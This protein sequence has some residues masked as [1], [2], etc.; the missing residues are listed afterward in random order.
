G[1]RVEAIVFAHRRVVDVDDLLEDEGHRE[2]EE[3]LLAGRLVGWKGELAV[4]VD[5]SGVAS[6]EGPEVDAVF[7][8]FVEE[9]VEVVAR[10]EEVTVI[11]H[12]RHTLHQ[13]LLAVDVEAVEVD[14]LPE[15]QDAA[16]SLGEAVP[17]GRA[18]QRDQLRARE[19]RGPIDLV[20]KDEPRVRI[21][22]R[23]TRRRAQ[24]GNR[25]SEPRHQ[26]FSSR[27]A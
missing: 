1:D 18:V 24:P 3:G 19:P 15:A 16:L 2:E 10:V 5:L 21:P 7:V 25:V 22:E 6:T 14:R 8:L 11:Q 23:A 4:G 20:R 26:T 12:S 13:C 9:V 17:Y 27:V